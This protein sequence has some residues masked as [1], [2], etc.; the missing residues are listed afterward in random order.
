[1]T[2]VR[3]RGRDNKLYPAVPA[4][5]AER[6]RIITLEHNLRCRDH[7]TFAQVRATLAEQYGVRR[8]IGA[9][10]RDLHEFEC[11]R[12]AEDGPGQP[13]AQPEPAPEPEPEP[14]RA[15][16]RRWGERPS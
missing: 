2:D 13:A 1:M 7:L 8:S 15:H 16:A 10:Y 5:Q 12:C 14:V 9:I 3:V 6:N 11:R 4:P